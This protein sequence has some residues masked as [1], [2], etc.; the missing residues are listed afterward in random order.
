MPS[1]SRTPLRPSARVP[2]SS[3]SLPADLVAPRFLWAPEDYDP[4]RTLGPEVAA[5]AT[6]AGFPPDPEQRLLLDLAFALDKDGKSLA[7]EIVL[8]APRQNLKTGFEKQYGLGQLFVRQEPLTMWSAHE[9]DTAMESL[10]DMEGLIDGSDLLRR[11]VKLT[12]RGDVA[13]HGASPQIELLPKYGR[14]RLKF[15]ARTSGGG[16]G[17]SGRKVILDE[18]YAL[19]AGHTGAL[20]PIMLAQPDPQ[21]VIGSS[22]CRPESAVLWDYVQRGRSAAQG[23]SREPRMVYAEWCTPEPEQACDLGASCSHTRGTAGCGCDKPEVIT[24]AHSAVR[25]GRILLQTI[26]DLRTSMPPEEYGR[27]VMGWHD[28]PVAGLPPVIPEVWESMADRSSEIVGPVALGLD[29]SMEDSPSFTIA[30]SGLRGDGLRH[31]EIT[32]RADEKT[33]ITLLDARPGT[34]WVVDRIVQIASGNRPC[35]LMLDPS[36]PAGQFVPDLLNRGFV[37]VTSPDDE[38]PADKWRLYLI[39]A[40]EYAGACGAMASDIRNNKWRHLGQQPLDDAVEG[41]R[42][43]Q[44]ADA[45][46]WSRKDSTVNISPFVAVTLARHGHVLFAAA[47]APAPFALWSS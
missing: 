17:L 19:Q 9:F 21:L 30:A 46:A 41:T 14:A 29:G 35:V 10:R 8:I 34:G 1:A 5:T 25:R 3:L 28:E 2:H 15:K 23:K 32:G 42:T 31:G 26:V 12:I 44:L 4:E 40:R 24:L 33:G 16:R 20:Y 43:R 39:G 36:G 18:A 13:T 27:E 6:L 37:K 47:D 38:I 11:R 45:Y 7:F 22:A